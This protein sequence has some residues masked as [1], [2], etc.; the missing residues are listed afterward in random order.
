VNG[1]A[2]ARTALVT[3]ANRGIGRAVAVRLAADGYVVAAHYGHD[4][5]AAKETVAL[6]GGNAFALH[7]DLRSPGGPAALLA[8]LD[9][10]LLARTGDTGLD[11][12]VNNAGVSPRGTLAQ[13]SVELFDEV[14]AVNVRAPFLLLKEALDR[15]RPSARVVNVSSTVTRAAYPDVVAYTMSKAALQA[16]APV[17]AAELGA[18]GV[19]VNTVTP[20]V[21]DTDMNAGW[22]RGNA[23]AQAKVA[24]ATALGRIAEADDVAG[25][26]VLLTRPEARWITGG[27]VDASGGGDL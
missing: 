22:L 24:A 26:I 2:R 16:M 5:A 21:T 8:A 18:R 6:A 9:A 3:G 10:E 7:A 20:G 14:F 23:E 19:T 12:L 25:A 11:V 4:E 15:L 27:L 13:T 1:A 17:V